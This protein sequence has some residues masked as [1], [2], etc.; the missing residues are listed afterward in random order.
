MC[1][2]VSWMIMSEIYSIRDWYY[3][4]DISGRDDTIVRNLL[5]K[6]LILRET[7]DKSTG[8]SRQKFTL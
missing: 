1:L 8:S 6:R 3:D 7:V 4:E 2:L 5:Y